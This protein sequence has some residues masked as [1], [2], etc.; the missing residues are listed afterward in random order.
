[1]KAQIRIIKLYYPTL[2]FTI[3][4]WKYDI[5][6]WITFWKYELAIRVWRKWVGF[7]GL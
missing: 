1:M 3:S 7:V 4:F 6:I 5:F 2:G